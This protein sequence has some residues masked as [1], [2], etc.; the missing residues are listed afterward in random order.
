MNVIGLECF[1]EVLD[2]EVLRVRGAE[3]P[4]VYKKAVPGIL[5]LVAVFEG[6]EGEEGG[7]PGEGGNDIFVP[8]EDIKGGTHVTAGE[9]GS[10]DVGRIV[11]GSLAFEDGASGFEQLRVVG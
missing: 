2:D 5:F 4:E 9:E 11:L 1:V 7:A 8:P 3:T 10:Q 6:F